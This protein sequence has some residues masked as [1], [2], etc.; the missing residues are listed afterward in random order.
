MW[1]LL[2]QQRRCLSP[3]L[4][5]KKLSPSCYLILYCVE[6][7]RDFVRYFISRIIGFF[8]FLEV[9]G[10]PLLL[11][12]VRFKIAC[13]FWKSGRVKFA[14]WDATVSLFKFEYK[15]PY[16]SPL[17]AAYLA[18]TFELI[19]P[20]LLVFGMMTRLAAIPLLIMTAVIQFAYLQHSDH[21]YWAILLG[22]LLLK[23]AGPLSLDAYS[24]KWDE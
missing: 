15:V 19:C 11:V 17:L 4:T 3:T 24:C 23:G 7:K 5:R 1:K 12:V 13:V 18:T 22:V 9:Y 8:R 2:L 16:I 6:V 21:T 20:V 14:H 10:W